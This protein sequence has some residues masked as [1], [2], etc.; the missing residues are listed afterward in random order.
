MIRRT[1]VTKEISSH[2]DANGSLSQKLPAFTST[3]N[4]TQTPDSRTEIILSQLP[5]KIADRYLA[6]GIRNLYD[7]QKDLLLRAEVVAG[8]NFVYSLPTSGGKSLVSEVLLLKAVFGA[9]GVSMPNTHLGPSQAPR[10]GILILPFVSLVEEK[11]ATL[12]ALVEGVTTVHGEDIKIE[13]YCGTHGTMPPPRPPCLYICTIEKASGVLNALFELGRIQELQTA[14]VDEIHMIGENGGRG[15]TLELVVAKILAGSPDVQLIGM[16]ATIPNIKDISRWIGGSYFEYGFRPVILKNYLVNDGIVFPVELMQDE[17]Y[18]VYLDKQEDKKN[19]VRQLY[20]TCTSQPDME[21]LFALVNEIFLVHSVIVFCATKS[22]AEKTALALA[23]RLWQFRQSKGEDIES[24]LEPKLELQAKDE[25]IEIQTS[26][27]RLLKFRVAYHHSGLT[28]EARTFIEEGFRKKR[29]CLLCCTSTLATGVN[30]PVRRVILSSPYVGIDFIKKS[31]YLQMIG[32]AGRAGLDEFGESFLVYQSKD[33]LKVEAMVKNT[34]EP[35]QSCIPL[36]SSVS[37]GISRLHDE[38]QVKLK[39]VLAKYV[40]EIIGCS[41]CCLQYHVLNSF[42]K[43]F[44]FPEHADILQSTGILALRILLEEGFISTHETMN[45][46]FSAI[47]TQQ[48]GNNHYELTNLGRSVLRSNIPINYAVPIYAELIEMQRSGLILDS[49]LHL[50]YFLTPVRDPI[51]PKWEIYRELFGKLNSVQSCVAERL[52]VCEYHIQQRAAGIRYPTIDCA[53]NFHKERKQFT[54]IRFWNALILSDI[55]NEIPNEDVSRKFGIPTVDLQNLMRNASYF[56]HSM[57]IFCE[58]MQWFSLHTIITSLVSRIVSGAKP[59]ILPLMKVRGVQAARARLLR[60]SGITSV[61]ELAK[62]D[63]DKLYE[64]VQIIIHQRK[65]KFS[66]KFRMFFAH[67]TA[68][69]LIQNAKQ[70]M[71]IKMSP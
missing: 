30:L 70:E 71:S 58:S 11:A 10:S 5:S 31:Q 33:R 4:T 1:S 60:Q 54:T 61:E 66:G 24:L 41:I 56:A 53:T 9:S 46:E 55:L 38:L 22:G 43:L 12:Q 25:G 15:I 64:S 2:V 40:L 7:W 36:C 8:K 42:S 57:S 65:L 59:D 50:L 26:L 51:E 52:R 13:A 6:N 49:D 29:I 47:P 44:A 23:N 48:S 16:S 39:L 28:S 32:R 27:S 34:T 3:G 37:S 69:L 14:V 67:S 21:T 62:A 18:Q 20:S 45:T 63:P 35:I 17:G 68:R 19:D